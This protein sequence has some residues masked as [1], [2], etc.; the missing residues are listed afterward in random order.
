MN[1]CYSNDANGIP[2]S[3]NDYTLVNLADTMA[4]RDSLFHDGRYK[5]LAIK[6]LQQINPEGH[7]LAI[8]FWINCLG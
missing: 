8:L 2:L 3:Y 7:S 5:W 4:L 1:G 6:M